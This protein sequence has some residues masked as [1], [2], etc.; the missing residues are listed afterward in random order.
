MFG[1]S[2]ERVAG[3]PRLRCAA[4]GGKPSPGMHLGFGIGRQATPPGSQLGSRARAQSTRICNFDVCLYGGR[5]CFSAL[6]F[7]ESECAS[8]DPRI[9]PGGSL[10]ASRIARSHPQ[11]RTPRWPENRVDLRRSRLPDSLSLGPGREGKR[12]VPADPWN[13][14]PPDRRPSPRMPRRTLRCPR[15]GPKPQA[16]RISISA[17]VLRLEL[18]TDIRG[19][20]QVQSPRRAWVWNHHIQ[21]MKVSLGAH[22]VDRDQVPADIAAAVIP[23]GLRVTDQAGDAWM[24]PSGAGP[25][26]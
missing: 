10:P 3:N 21:R 16:H 7:S 5:I 6:R 2:S 23:V 25:S 1:G 13:V 12:A 19:P 24:R 9:R 26:R 15:V 14:Q 4:G 11:L 18:P 22:L 20:H 17:R 8:P